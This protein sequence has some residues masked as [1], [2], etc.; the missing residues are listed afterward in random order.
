MRLG[1][2]GGWDVRKV[3][4]QAVEPREDGV[5]TLPVPGFA[6][7]RTHPFTGAPAALGVVGSGY[8]PIQNEEH[9]EFL[10]HVTD[11]SGAVFDTAG[12]LRGGRQIF[13]PMQLPD[14]MT[15]GGTDRVDLNIAALNSHDGSSAFR[16][17]V[18]RVRVVCANTQAAALSNHVSSIS[19]R[20]TAGAR[21]AVQ[22]ARDVLGLTFEYCEAFQAEA[23]R[24]LDTAMTE[25]AFDDL[26]S[27]VFGST[28]ADAP[29]RTRK[30]ESQ[31]RRTLTALFADA[32]TQA[33]IRGSAWAGYQAVTEY[34]DHF[35][36]VRD[37]YDAATARATRLLTADEPAKIKRTAW[38]ALTPA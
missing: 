28:N 22:A 4:L 38:A 35:A 10:N 24:L 31:R 18:T 19:I 25:A 7:V 17:L 2:L 1:H 5:H 33:N 15:V 27:R 13:V 6:T 9:A 26:I 8:T 20:H 3:P 36:P 30:A 34:V 16:V 11:Q 37:K 29:A 23:E 21:A 14:S 32:E 12:S